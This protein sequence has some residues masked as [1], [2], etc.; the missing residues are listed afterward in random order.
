MNS[1]SAKIR[2]KGNLLQQDNFG[3][4][5]DEANYDKSYVFIEQ[6]IKF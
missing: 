2:T 5:F 4:C 6:E 3:H 1:N